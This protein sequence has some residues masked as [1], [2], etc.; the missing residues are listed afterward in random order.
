ME[1]LLFYYVYTVYISI[2]IYI[3]IYLHTR[4]VLDIRTPTSDY[5]IADRLCDMYLTKGVATYFIV[6]VQSK[7]HTSRW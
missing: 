2:N 5:I 6:Q 7:L 3:F 4:H 1:H